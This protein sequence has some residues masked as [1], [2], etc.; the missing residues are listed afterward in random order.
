MLIE[1]VVEEPSMVR[2]LEHLVPKVLA[3]KEIH[4]KFVN[5]KDKDRLLKKLPD[6]F[7]GYARRAENDANFRVM[8]LID[9]DGGDCAVLKKQMED[10]AANVGLLTKAQAGG[11]GNFTAVNRIVMQELEAWFLGDPRAL[12][13]AFQRLPGSFEERE[14]YR[15]PEQNRAWETLQRLLNEH[16][17]YEGVEPFPKP[18]IANLVAPHMS[19]ERG[20][21][22]APSFAAFIEGLRGCV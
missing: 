15:D 8:V 10:M 20:V 9:N 12:R 2:A 14:S 19:I 1:A 13:Q 21:N 7:H 3:G 22:R 4:L 11:D 6:L 17:Y 5:C 18:E 16:G